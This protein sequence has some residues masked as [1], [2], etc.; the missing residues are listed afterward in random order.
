MGVPLCSHVRHGVR[1][2]IHGKSRFAAGILCVLVSTRDEPTPR[3]PTPPSHYRHCGLSLCSVGKDT[4]TDGGLAS[5]IQVH[6]ARDPEIEITW[7][8][9]S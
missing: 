5:T 9:T 4:L 7:N 8:V 2:D 6:G 3:V 1:L